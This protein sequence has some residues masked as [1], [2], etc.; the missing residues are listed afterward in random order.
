MCIQN[1]S[2]LFS[3]ILGNSYF[4]CEL[5]WCRVFWTCFTLGLAILHWLFPFLSLSLSSWTFLLSLYLRVCV[6]VKLWNDSHYKMLFRFDFGVFM[7][8]VLYF[9]YVYT[10]IYVHIGF[11]SYGFACAC[12]CLCV[13]VRCRCRSCVFL[14]L[15]ALALYNNFYLFVHSL[16]RWFVRSLVRSFRF[17]CVDWMSCLYC[18]G[19]I[20]LASLV[21]FV[22]YRCCCRSFVTHNTLHTIANDCCLIR[23]NPCFSFEKWLE[24]REEEEEKKRRNEK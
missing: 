5:C 3:I 22:C 23:R 20:F 17:I 6:S 8:Y 7:S 2:R 4:V 15:S 9:T 12:V 13:C 16:I 19:N 1:I 14:E 21:S 18:I 11:Y 10:N 24:Q